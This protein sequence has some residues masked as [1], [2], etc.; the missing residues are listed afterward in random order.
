MIRFNRLSHRILGVVLTLLAVSVSGI[1]FYSMNVAGCSLGRMVNDFEVSMAGSLAGELD[2]TFNRFE[3]VLTS[4]GSLMKSKVTPDM[5]NPDIAAAVAKQFTGQNGKYMAELSVQS[6]ETRS[7]FIIFNPELF[8]NKSA[9][10]IGFQRDDADSQCRAM[11][12]ADFDPAALT[13]RKNPS[14]A[15]FWKPL[16]T[17]A[18]YWSDITASDAGGEAVTYSM[19]IFI[20]GRIAA[21]TG[22]TFDFSFVSDI[23]G[24]LKVYDRGYPF[25]LNR[26]LRFLYHPEHKFDGPTLREIAGGAL[27]ALGDELFRNREGRISYFYEGSEKTL[28]YRGLANGYI[29]AAAATTD[30]SMAAVGEMRRAVYVGMVVV[31]LLSTVVVLLFSRS[32]TRPLRAVAS[33]ARETARTGDLTRRLTVKSRIQEIRDVAE[34]LNDLT[35]GTADAVRNIID[36]SR[37]VFARASDMSAAAEE[38]SASIEEVIALAA[39]VL[40]GSAEASNASDAARSGVEEVSRGA[41]S[42]ARAAAEM[43]EQAREIA[44]SAEKGG[45]ALREM[46]GMITEVSRSGVKVSGAVDDLASSVAGITGFIDTIRNIADQ[47]NLLALNAAI[48]AARAGEAGRGFAVVAEEVRKLAEES[49]RAA[50]EVGRVIGEVAGKTENAQEDQKGSVERINA[51]VERAQATKEII[52]DVVLKVA[53]I[54]ENVQS[55]A[56]TM[57]EQSAG[58]EEMAAGMDSV[59]RSSADISEQIGLINS[60]MDEQGRM[61]EGMT[62]T[63][64]DLVRLSEEMERSVERFK[65]EEAG[66]VP[67]WIESQIGGAP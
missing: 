5:V 27:A 14:T 30:E 9:Y 3:G 67:G 8:G 49:N 53:D 47:T 41:Q 29:V 15:W 26:D 58:A 43:G 12:G 24:G 10:V 4:L 7:V 37:K 31:I 39:R 60:S 36:S 11:N 64:A 63:A 57:E 65:V 22:M 32:I 6:P 62:A 35:D 17:G 2:A 54:S 50:G 56:A 18:P 42:G 16:E 20:G 13:D 38:G 21:V 34:A 48:E 23:L 61:T 40:A 52:D 28:A 51:L 44:S 33:D 1:A 45:E 46:V 55:I 59:A 19:P 25:L 66:L